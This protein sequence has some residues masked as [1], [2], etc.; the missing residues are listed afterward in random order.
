MSTRKITT[1]AGD[2]AFSEAGAGSRAMLMLHGNSG[3]KESFAAQMSEVPDGWRVIAPDLVGHGESS[4]ALD[5]ARDYT[6]AGHADYVAELSNELGLKHVVI[7]GFSL[8]GHIALELLTR[9]PAIVGLV[10]VST[11]PFSKSSLGL[12]AAFP[13]G[14]ALLLATKETLL[15]EEIEAFTQMHGV[16]TPADYRALRRAIARSDGRSRLVLGGS[17]LQPETIDQLYLAEHCDLPVAVVVGDW[18]TVV[19]TQ[20]IQTVRFPNVWRGKVH[21]IQGAGH[22]P[23]I[24]H[25]RVFNDLLSNY[26]RELGHTSP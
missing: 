5:P 17:L 2:I 24:S 6:L 20:H 16:M 23:Q 14:P 19:N 1:R 4:D 10:L 21:R 7:V 22:A 18:D 9:M 13:P 8:G 25:S 15:P 26:L 3:S 11:P 12:E